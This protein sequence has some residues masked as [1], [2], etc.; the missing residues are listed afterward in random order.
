[1]TAKDEARRGLDAPR[2]LFD[3]VDNLLTE[4]D[5][6]LEEDPEEFVRSY[7]QG[8]G[9]GGGN[10]FALLHSWI[11]ALGPRRGAELLELVSFLGWGTMGEDPPPHDMSFELLAL[12]YGTCTADYWAR[13]I[14]DVPD[15]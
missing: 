2:E 11:E 13:A 5:S 6:V 8:G 1:M 10:S 3:G 15:L 7:V 14:R 12:R 9:N 4:I